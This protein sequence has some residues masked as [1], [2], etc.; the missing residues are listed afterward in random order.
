MSLLAKAT[1]MS[2]AS[3]I[4]GCAMTLLHFN[5]IGRLSSDCHDANG[6]RG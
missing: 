5:N 1:H 2:N 4:W 3:L 6:V